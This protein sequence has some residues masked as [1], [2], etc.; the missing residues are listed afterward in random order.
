MKNNRRLFSRTKKQ[1][2]TLTSGAEAIMLKFEQR[3]GIMTEAEAQ[4]W[5]D[6][7]ATFA[8]NNRLKGFGGNNQVVQGEKNSDGVKGKKG[9]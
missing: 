5:E 2:Q 7:K 8:R 6:N 4:R 9:S 1:S 3:L